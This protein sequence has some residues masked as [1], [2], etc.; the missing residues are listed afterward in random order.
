MRASPS[1]LLVLGVAFAVVLGGG[2]CTE[3]PVYVQPQD[4]IEVGI[5]EPGMEVTEASARVILP[6]ALETEEDALERAELA[7]ELGTDVPYVKLDDLTISV[8]YS[9]RNLTDQDG[10]ARVKLNGGNEY[11]YFVP[12]NFVVDPDEDEEPPPLQGDIP[13]LLGPGASFSGVF[14]EDAVREAAI[15]IELIT[16]GGANAF[17]ALLSINE[18]VTDMTTMDGATIPREVFGQMIQFDL[19]LEGTR[20]MVMEYTV[21]VRDH[22]GILHDALLDAPAGELTAFAPAEYVPPPPPPE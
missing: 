15:D 10:E 2:A 13:I 16:R 5:G 8:E 9:I 14:R 12:T 19:T 21:R 20:H 1:M 3:D 4:A 18:D 17:A 6:V 22:R 11:F 7:A